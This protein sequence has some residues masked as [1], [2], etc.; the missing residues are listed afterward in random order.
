MDALLQ[1]QFEAGAYTRPLSAQPEPFLVIDPAHRH[2]IS[3][4]TCLR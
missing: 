2:R 1:K 3:H 4:K